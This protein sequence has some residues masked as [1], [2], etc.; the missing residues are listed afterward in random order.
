M[1]AGMARGAHARGKLI[2]F[3][4]GRKIL[5]SS[6]AKEVFLRNPNVAMPGHEHHE[7]H[8]LEWVNY[9]I[10][11]RIYQHTDPRNPRYIWNYEF[12]A[13]PGEL[14]FDRNETEF[15]VAAGKGFILIEPN[16][17]YHKPTAVN[18]QWAVGRYQ[19]VVDA[20]VGNS[21]EVVQLDYSG[22]RHRLRGVRKICL[23]YTSDAADERSSVD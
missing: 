23:L 21:C 17:P 6:R 11:H 10:G 8:R 13:K 15:S 22:I 20:L 7:R 1:A 9:H 14:F 12:K 18:K 2:A 3:G 5:W 16:L 4:D 19:E